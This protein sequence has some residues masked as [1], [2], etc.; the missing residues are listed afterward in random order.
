MAVLCF[1]THI[2]EIMP[3]RSNSRGMKLRGLIIFAGDPP[4]DSGSVALGFCFS[5][6][7]NVEIVLPFVGRK[8]VSL[9]CLS[10]IPWAFY[11]PGKLF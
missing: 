3:Y 9:L 11:L 1:V 2:L 7:G 6:S 4:E 10:C 8:V 5:A